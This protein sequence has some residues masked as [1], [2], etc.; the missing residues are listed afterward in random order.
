MEDG[1]QTATAQFAAALSRGDAPAA[2]ALYAEN[3]KLLTSAADLVEG[4]QHIEAY[5]RAGMAIGLSSV[6]LTPLEIEVGIE[7]AIEIGRYELGVAADVADSGKYVVL[8]R[9]QTDGTWRR[10]VDVF[11]PEPKGER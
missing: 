10:A 11:N 4:R 5:W 7:T 1:I 3:G 9:R 6:A 8:H 2:A